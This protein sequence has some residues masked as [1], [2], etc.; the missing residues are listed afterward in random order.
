MNPTTSRTMIWALFSFDA[1]GEAEAACYALT[2][3]RLPFGGFLSQGAGYERA[4]KVRCVVNSSRY[5]AAVAR[6]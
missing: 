4:V 2:R 1:K 5:Q 6:G 3:G